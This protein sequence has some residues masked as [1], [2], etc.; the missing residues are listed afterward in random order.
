MPKKKKRTKDAGRYKV[1]AGIDTSEGRR[2]EIGDEIQGGV[3]LDLDRDA[4]L[5]MNAIA[6]MEPAE[7]D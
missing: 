3:L 5:E 1:L 7:G 4:F 2:F 6:L